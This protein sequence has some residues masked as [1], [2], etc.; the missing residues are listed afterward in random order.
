MPE[1][2]R[3]S[4]RALAAAVVLVGLA[5][6]NSGT[7]LD[8]DDANLSQQQAQKVAQ[9]IS[10]QAYTDDFTATSA[11]ADQSPGGIAAATTV[12]ISRNRP[13]QGGGS[14][15]WSVSAYRND[16]GDSL[17]VDGTLDYDSCT[18]TV[19]DSTVT[20]TSADGSA[21]AFNGTLLRTS[22][23][24]IDYSSTL[25]G[26]FQWEFGGRNGKSGTCA[27]DLETDVTATGVG[28]SGEGSIEAT[29]LGQVC[30]HQVERTFSLEHS[31]S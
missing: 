11:N 30:G 22:P 8:A 26:S 14:V 25:T 4:L 27:L 5:A 23:S 1:T 7:G 15:F 6:C 18:S 21:F 17:S 12:D 9:A 10:E 29:T 20:V 24:E 3:E 13:C 31:S 28:T 16:A 19:G 2:I